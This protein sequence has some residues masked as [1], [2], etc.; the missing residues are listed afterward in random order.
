MKITAFDTEIVNL[1][2]PKPAATAIHKI[3][4]VGCILLRLRGDRGAVGESFLFTING[5]R[6]KSFDAMLHGLKEFVLAK[7]PYHSAA[8]GRDIWAAINPIGQR[9]VTVAA[10]S[11]IDTACWDLVGKDLQKPL[12]HIFGACRDRVK[13]YASGGLWL[14]QSVDE[15]AAEAAQFVDQ[16]FRAMKMRVGCARVAE[17]VKR[18]RAVRKAVGDEIELMADINQSL[19]AKQAIRLGRALEEFQLA[20]LEEPVAADNLA[21]H[22]RVTAALDTPIA[23][24]ETEYGRFAMR[25]MIDARACDILTPDLQRIGGLTEMLRVAALAGA[26]HMDISTHMFTEHSL[27]VAGAA[28]N[29]ISVEHTGWFAKLFNEELEMADGELLIPRRPGTGFTFKRNPGK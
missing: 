29:C 1:P 7:N 19:S 28:V 15:L 2:L 13:T 24:G 18:V 11:A 8:I 9:G 5:A 16:G 23:S 12:H 25:Q 17:D 26:H 22:A 20:W 4:S 3:E 27:C 6:L 21:G 14:S 10:L